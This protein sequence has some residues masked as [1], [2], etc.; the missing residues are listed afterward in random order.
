MKLL[1]MEH[2]FNAHFD[3]STPKQTPLHVTILLIAYV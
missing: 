2:G 1:K 3:Q